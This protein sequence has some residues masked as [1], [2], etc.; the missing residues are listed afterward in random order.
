MIDTDTPLRH[1]DD[2]IKT[3]KEGAMVPNRDNEDWQ[4]EELALAARAP[5]YSDLDDNEV[6]GRRAA[7]ND[8]R[9]WT[10]APSTM[11]CNKDHSVKISPPWADSHEY[12]TAKPL[13][14]AI[15]WTPNNS[16]RLYAVPGPVEN[17]PMIVVATRLTTGAGDRGHRVV[18]CG[19]YSGSRELLP[20]SMEDD[21]A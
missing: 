12:V 4:S 8:G 14:F 17:K 1:D 7:T 5:S 20:V 3:T 16:R 19:P 9:E 13:H 11:R 18:Y 10:V 21:D 6:K 15:Q 2:S